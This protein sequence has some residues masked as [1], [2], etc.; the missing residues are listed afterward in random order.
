M[1]ERLILDRPNGRARIDGYLEKRGL[2][3]KVGGVDF[4]HFEGPERLFARRASRD[5]L[6]LHLLEL[7]GRKEKEEAAGDRPP[8]T[9]N[10]PSSTTR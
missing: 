6:G 4:A 9:A 7:R 1:S 10:R 3:M 5:D 2:R 8:L